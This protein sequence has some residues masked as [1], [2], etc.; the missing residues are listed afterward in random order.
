MC[1]AAIPHLLRTGGNI[2]NTSSTAALAGLPWGAAYAASKGGVLALTYGLAVE[3]AKQGLRVNAVCPGS[4]RTPMT[5]HSVLPEGHDKSL[6]PRL[7]PL[8]KPGAPEN[9]ASVIA[10]LASEDGAHLN[11]EGI[12]VDGGMLA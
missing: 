11:G 4:V 9:V 1:R 7:W 3:Y 6:L 2:V 12:C 10:M 8:H 5:S